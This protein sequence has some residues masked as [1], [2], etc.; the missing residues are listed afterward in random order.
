MAECYSPFFNKYNMNT[1]IVIYKS[2]KKAIIIIVTGFVLAIIGWL[3]F[4]FTYNDVAGWSFVI[5]AVLSVIL[6][7][8]NW[9]DRKPYII[10]TERGITETTTIRE[11]I[12][13]S[14]I[15]Q[16]DEFFYFGQYFIRLLV[17]RGYKPSLIHST[18]FNRFD[19]LYEKKGVK[20]IF[21]RVSSLELGS[22]KLTQ[23]INKMM[24]ANS[25]NRIKNQ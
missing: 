14:A 3:F 17:D 15:H 24:I 4:Q 6:G 10:L 11:E 9:F 8:G 25:T 16:V 22:A 2:R 5:L 19:R 13:W 21:I 1:E 23:L 12:E 18:W 7:L 20:A